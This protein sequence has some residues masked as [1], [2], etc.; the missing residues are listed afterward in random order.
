M[1]YG[2][3]WDEIGS[4]KP[5]EYLNEITTSV[6][7]LT[8][9][10]STASLIPRLSPRRQDQNRGVASTPA[11]KPK[12]R[13]AMPT[14]KPI[15]KRP[16]AA[17]VSRAAPTEEPKRPRA[18]LIEKRPR[19]SSVSRVPLNEKPKRPATGAVVTA[20]SDSIFADLRE[21]EPRV[22]RYNAGIVAN[23]HLKAFANELRAMQRFRQREPH[24][25]RLKGL[26]AQ[27][28]GEIAATDATRQFDKAFKDA[29]VE[30]AEAARMLVSAEAPDTR[31][32]AEEVGMLATLIDSV[33]P[34]PQK[35]ACDGVLALVTKISDGMDSQ[36][37]V[38]RRLIAE[39]KAVK[40]RITVLREERK[41]TKAKD[42]DEI[43]AELAALEDQQTGLIE[44][45]ATHQRY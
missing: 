29:A 2:D 22:A 20:D 7:S 36:V 12:P 25:T 41:Q 5:P 44:K 37:G 40:E 30:L 33:Q 6:D 23:E 13:H 14:E 16:R 38:Y 28:D 11:E 17:S 43:D 26:L 42:R 45:L 34:N 10:R 18:T 39:M 35:N 8:K 21:F 19:A 31:R 1:S 3:L 15:E 4:V 27:I 32:L 24:L 9:R